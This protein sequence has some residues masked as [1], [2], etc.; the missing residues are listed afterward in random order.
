MLTFAYISTWNLEN[1]F[2]F[3]G[4]VNF[5]STFAFVLAWVLGPSSIE[6]VEYADY[7]LYRR[8]VNNRPN[9]KRG[10]VS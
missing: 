10:G 8:H 1:L 7:N 9:Q 4:K 6:K 5:T 2:D 3:N